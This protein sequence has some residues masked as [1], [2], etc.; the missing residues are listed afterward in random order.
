MAAIATATISSAARSSPP[1]RAPAA[2]CGTFRS[3]TTTSGTTTCRLRRCLFDARIGGATVPA[4]AVS[5]KNGLLFFLNRVNGE[6]IH[7]IEE[8][9]APASDVPGEAAAPTQPYPARDA[10]ARPHCLRLDDVAQLAPEH[11][12]WCRDVDRGQAMVAG[13]LYHPVHPQSAHDQLSGSARRQQ[14]G[15][16]RA[17][18]GRRGSSISTPV[19]SA[20]SPSS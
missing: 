4:V 3:F 9:P 14:L 8:R 13:G 19:T 10:A 20:K 17:R 2:T 16:R 15:R 7:A 6:P 12:Q 11:T 5:S 1:T 18:S